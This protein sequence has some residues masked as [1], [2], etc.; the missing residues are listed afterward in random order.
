MT[1]LDKIV[2]LIDEEAS[3]SAYE[4][5]NSAEEKAKKIVVQAK[6]DAENTASSIIKNAENQ[7]EFILK[8]AISLANLKEREM[9]L[10]AKRE[11]INY[12]FDE[13]KKSLRSL[14]VEEYFE[15]IL[16]LCKKYVSPL[17]GEI[18]FSSA[19]LKKV[20][21]DFQ[22]NLSKLV[23]SIGGELYISEQTRDINGGFILSYGDIEENCSFDALFEINFD[24]LSDKVNEILFS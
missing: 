8:R 12:V 20:P 7:A 10:E 1:G 11:Q 23:N 19:D 3:A 2:N 14:P 5:I 13:T 6:A 17:K 18:I 9:I 4:I 22:A 21:Q 16:K 15:L 24:F